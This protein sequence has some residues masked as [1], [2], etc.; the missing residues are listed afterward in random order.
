MR[1]VSVFLAGMF[2][3]LQASDSVNNVSLNDDDRG[4]P[5]TSV[6]IKANYPVRG[7]KNL[8]RGTTSFIDASLCKNDLEFTIQKGN[9]PPM[10]GPSGPSVRYRLS[11]V[12]PDAIRPEVSF[13]YRLR[14]Q[15]HIN[16]S[17]DIW[18]EFALNGAL[19]R[20]TDM[21]GGIDIDE[22]D[23]RIDNIFMPS[24]GPLMVPPPPSTSSPDMPGI[25]PSP[26]SIGLK[27]G[28]IGEKDGVTLLGEKFI[29]KAENDGKELK[30]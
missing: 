2:A 5:T 14:N 4:K 12:C 17:N 25:P 9:L 29:F 26:L 15:Q 23:I 19:Q 22:K 13:A 21:S 20:L 8:Y 1:Y 16:N 7:G 28:T 10:S 6:T 30:N 27:L 18:I 24:T 11:A 3:S